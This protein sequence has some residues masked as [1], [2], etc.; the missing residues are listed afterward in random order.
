MRHLLLSAAALLTLTGCYHTTVTDLPEGERLVSFVNDAPPP[1]AHTSVILAEDVALW[2]A[3]DAC[4]TGFKV[5]REIM[6]LGSYPHTYNIVVRCRV[7]VA[8]MS[9]PVPAQ[10]P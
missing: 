9:T 6:D 7:P 5:T 2:R 10:T 3:A 8:A 1:F 4:P